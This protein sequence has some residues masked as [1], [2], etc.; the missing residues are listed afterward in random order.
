[1]AMFTT[2]MSKQ[3]RIKCLDLEIE[4]K[5]REAERWYKRLE[6]VSN[7]SVVDKIIALEKEINEDIDQL[8]DTKRGK[9]CQGVT[10][11]REG[12][13]AREEG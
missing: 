1:V 3:E 2:A 7:P 8:I 6:Y 9:R 13:R 5:M 11:Y 10:R 4:R 12:M